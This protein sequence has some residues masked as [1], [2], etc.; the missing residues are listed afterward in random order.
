[1]RTKSLTTDVL[2]LPKLDGSLTNC[3]WVG[4]SGSGR[5]LAL[6]EAAKSSPVPCVYVV[7]TSSEIAI[8]ARDLKFF[9]STIPIQVVP[10]WETLPYDRF[11]SHRE[12]VSQ[13]ILVLNRIVALNQ[14]VVVISLRS[15]LQRIA[16]RSW[17][18]ENSFTLKVNEIHGRDDLVSR[19][20]ALGY[21]QQRQVNELGDLA[22][23]GS[24]IDVFPIGESHPVRLDFLDET[25]ESIRY[26]STT[27]QRSS[28][29]KNSTKFLPAREFPM[30]PDSIARFKK[31]WRLQFG[32]ERSSIYDDVSS[33]I[34]SA[35]IEYYLP[36]FFLKTDSVLDYLPTDSVFMFNDD[37]KSSADQVVDQY[38]ARFES[39]KEVGERPILEPHYLLENWIKLEERLLDSSK[40]YFAS[41][42][43]GVGERESVTFSQTKKG[44]KFQ[45]KI[46][47]TDPI[48][49]FVK[50]SKK[51]EGRILIV[52]PSA[53]RCETLIELFG[54]RD[55]FL[56]KF[57]SW[58]Q[59][60]VS[61][62]K[63]GV[64]CGGLSEGLEIVDPSIKVLTENELLGH[65]DTPEKS[66]RKRKK[67]ERNFDSILQNLT[68][69]EIGNSVVHED[70]GVGRYAGLKVLTTVGVVEE[71]VEIVYA[72]EDKLY[73]PV[74]NIDLVSRYSSSN[75]DKAPLHKLGSGQWEKVCKK[76]RKK[77]KDV[78][79]DILETYAKREMQR[80][81][82][83]ASIDDS[84]SL[85]SG[86][87]EYEETE[88]QQKAIED[89]TVD[90]KS[91]K[92]MDRLICGDVG[93]G[94]TEIAMR[95]VFLAVNAGFQVAV[96]V[97][98]TLLARQHFETF[99]KRFSGWPIRIAQL[100]RLKARVL[101]EDIKKDVA[102]GLVDV[103]IGT[104]KLLGSDISY[105]NL[106]L[107]VIDEEHRFGVSQKEKIKSIRGNVHILTLTAT[108]IPRTLNFALSGMRDLS[109]VA[110]PPDNRI[111]VKTYVSEYSSEIIRE[112]VLRELGRGGQ[113]Y[114]IHNEVK[115]ILKI[116]RELESI[117]PEARISVTH[118]QLAERDLESRMAAFYSG[119]TNL[120]LSTTIVESGLDLPNA[121]TIIINRA[122]KFGLAQL[123][124]LRGRVGRSHHMSY[125][126]LFVPDKKTLTIDASRRLDAIESL[127]Q[128]GMGFLL[129][130][131]DLEIRGAGEILGDEQSGEIEDMGFFLFNEILSRTVESLKKETKNAIHADSRNGRV[132]IDLHIPA[133]L[134]ENYLPDVHSRLILYKRISAAEDHDSL[135]SLRE[136]IIDRYGL[137]G[138]EV[139]NLFKIAKAKADMKKIGV[140]KVD[141]GPKGGKIE[142][143][144]DTNVAP[145]KLLQLLESKDGYKMRDAH[146][147]GISKNLSEAEERFK[148]IDFIQ[149]NLGDIDE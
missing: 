3:F 27:D 56:E 125:A 101:A 69:L 144:P 18:S 142:F 63:Y 143:S 54:N 7:N 83:I 87:F 77:I 112:S 65:E 127:D 86:Q 136:E 94:K 53:G 66:R 14:G 57:D 99:S 80:G 41:R 140:K 58:H 85:F 12:I 73:I 60:V 88:D 130:N 75:S 51:T 1:M 146:T 124:Q 148:E 29:N 123:Y 34:C 98:T 16:P 28:G 71:F 38:Q 119:E 105:E 74:R 95:A 52:V 78:A 103:V 30:D 129:A 23:R 97:P 120:L 19:L 62:G 109:L 59:F 131:H 49:S 25:L 84:Y 20:R 47:S 43:D 122:D 44:L 141:L 68:E 100:S 6:A 117:V 46:T 21:V 64:V 40:L 139:Q 42:F 116:A 45:F 82:K 8:V 115:T 37:V 13:R 31:N 126:H 89:V 111:A 33:G 2:K 138:E 70:Y 48:G 17:I 134:P 72:D 81:H 107:L 110:S 108:P 113:I 11:S 15:L 93:F 102:S 114:F 61:K 35:G 91:G 10:D 32:S 50:F 128:L 9:D 145:G 90:L 147:L 5:I 118:G 132:E 26:F 133:L 96:L 22:V 55:I 79:A 36:F 135:I 39:L 104:Q 4:L 67:S 106:G 76:A 24:I 92:P 121:N 149:Q 137:I